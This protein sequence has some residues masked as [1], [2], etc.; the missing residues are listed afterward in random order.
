MADLV[1]DVSFARFVYPFL[2]APETFDGRVAAAT[3]AAWTG[4]ER[5]LPVWGGQ[6]FPE[7]DLLP[8]VANY[9]NREEGGPST[10]RLWRMTQNAL[11]S[12]N[13]GLGAQAD[14]TL[15]CTSGPYTLLLNSIQLAL[16]RV[17]VGFL[18]IEA[19]P[20]SAE[21]NTWLD[22]VH[23]FRYLRR[24]ETVWVEATR[25]TGPG[26][27]E[28][29]FPEPAGGLA[30]HPDGGGTFSE[31]VDAVLRTAA[32]PGETQPWWSEVFVPGQ[33]LPYVCLF[34]D[35]LDAV[36]RPKRLHQLRNFFH[37]GQQLRPTV[38]DLRVDDHPRLLQY[39]DGQWFVFSL[40]G[41]AFVAFDAP[42]DDRF[43]RDTLPQ[44]IGSTYFLLF[45]LAL[46]QRFAMMMLSEEVARNWL[47]GNEP[48]REASFARI[49]DTL[50]AFTARGRFAQVM[51]QEH[52][53]AVYLRW[54][55]TFQVDR[56][57]AEVSDEVREMANYVLVR[58]TER[59]AEGERRLE[60]RVN[61]IGLLVGMPALVLTYF[62]TLGARDWWVGIVAG[63]GA[64]LVGLGVLWGINRRAS[65]S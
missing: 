49:R 59:I 21:V 47:V 60:R 12:P 25:R 9:L 41:G 1:Q 11:R 17:G 7:D 44:H 13:G 24:K 51:Q 2:F 14:W 65:G 28:P 26:K 62:S 34:E 61:Q 32:L 55:E 42:A 50:L 10:A 8:H 35:G 18:T 54:Q 52:H 37:C 63:V 48:E 39:T 53:H 3:K 56:L 58:R 22:F 40:D 16:F 20:K 36:E 57:Y 6:R 30:A 4:R 45:L 23:F 64:L 46:H 38:A 5:A 43:F 31:I 19:R 15:G 27:M 33:A 29:F